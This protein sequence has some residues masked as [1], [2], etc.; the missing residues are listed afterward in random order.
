MYSRFVASGG[1]DNFFTIASV[2]IP[3]FTVEERERL[4]RGRMR[5]DLKSEFE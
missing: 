1:Y 3:T 4:R 5:L 2:E